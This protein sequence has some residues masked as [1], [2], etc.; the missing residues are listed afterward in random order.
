MWSGY[1]KNH[2][3]AGVV[4]CRDDIAHSDDRNYWFSHNPYSA[5]YSVMPR[6]AFHAAQ[7]TLTTR[8][9]THVFEFRTTP[10]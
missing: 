4:A 9:Q 10:I 8:Y 7:A 5:C 6:A 1:V 2:I 3:G